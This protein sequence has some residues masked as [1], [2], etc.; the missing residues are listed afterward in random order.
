VETEQRIIAGLRKA[1]FIASPGVGASCGPGDGEHRDVTAAGWWLGRLV[2]RR[3]SAGL[4]CRKKWSPGNRV[5][6]VSRP[7]KRS[8]GRAEG[9]DDACVSVRGPVRLPAVPYLQRIPL[10]TELALPPRAVEMLLVSLF[11][12]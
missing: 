6:H 10:G 9:C 12:T 8:S 1:D 2:K 7:G 11:T 5:S 4:S 3:S